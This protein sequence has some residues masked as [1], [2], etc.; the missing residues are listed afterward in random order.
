MGR[1]HRATAA[2][3]VGFCLA[4]PA[5]AQTLRGTILDS[6][7][8]SPIELA[9]VGLFEEGRPLIVAALAGSDGAFE[10]TAP[11]SGAYFLYV[12]RQGYETV[13][14]GVFELGEDGAFDVRVGMQPAPIELAPVYVEAEGGES[15][16]ERVGFYDRAVSG[17]G[18]FLMGEE[19][20]RT[21]VERLTDA[22]F[23][24]PRLQVDLDRPLTGVAALQ[25]PEIKII[26]GA[27]ELCSPS[28]YVDGH[29]V[30]FGGR[31]G[32]RVR[33]DDYAAP[34]EIEAVEI[35]T[36]A[37]EVPVTFDAINDCGVIA[38]WTRIR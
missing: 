7:T 6:A 13:M 26:R 17:R 14:E 19:I 36:R 1:F 38:L 5:E 12:A 20:R 28:L 22:F 31:N 3:L 34:S 23:N 35:Y 21:A 11:E 30:A 10:L 15:P 33:P 2:A 16:L 24:I 27:G 4:V 29:I 25:A 32:Q 9:Y 8:G 37:S 18:T